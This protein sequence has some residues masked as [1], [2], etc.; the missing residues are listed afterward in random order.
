M[1][2]FELALAYVDN[3]QQIG[4]DDEGLVVRIRN[5]GIF[6]A[7]IRID[8]AIRIGKR[9]NL[10]RANSFKVTWFIAR[11]RLRAVS[12]HR[13]PP[14]VAP[15]RVTTLKPGFQSAMQSAHVR[16]HKKQPHW[17]ARANPRH[18]HSNDPTRVYGPDLRCRLIQHDEGSSC[19]VVGVRTS[20]RI[21]LISWMAV[22]GLSRNTASPYG[23]T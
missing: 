16:S 21:A 22:Q 10:S 2:S 7:N 18:R 11:W 5:Q 19:E 6:V 17:I 8:L 9:P 4:F 20:C 13:P 1:H 23:P 15:G 12:R 14:P 3:A